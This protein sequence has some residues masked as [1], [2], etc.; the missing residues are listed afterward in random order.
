MLMIGALLMTFLVL[1]HYKF[2]LSSLLGDAA[3]QSG[4]GAAFLEPGLRYGVENA[5]DATRD[6]LQQ[7]GPALARHRAGARHGRPAAHPDPVLH[8]PDQPDRPQE[9]ALGDRHHR[10]LLPV[11]PGPRLRRGGP[12]RR[13][14]DHRAGQGGQHRRP[15]AGPGARHRYFGGD[16]GGVDP[17]GDH[18]GGRV[19]HDP[20]RGGRPHPGVV[21][22]RGARLLRQRDQAGHRRRARRGPGRPD[23][24]PG[25]RRGRDRPV[26]LRAEPERGVPGGARVRGGRLGQPAGDPLQPVLEAVQHLRARCGRSTAA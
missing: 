24:G 5:G 2:N 17:A 21:V 8:R 16:T 3:A 18:R 4:K 1:A 6:L 15:A 25:H 14:G 10:R 7:D 20:G 23:L 26:D 9:R 22:E 13:Q 11:H 19:R 12:G